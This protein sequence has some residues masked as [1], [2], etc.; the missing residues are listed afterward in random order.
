MSKSLLELFEKYEDTT[1]PKRPYIDIATCVVWEMLG[2][3]DDKLSQ[4]IVLYEELFNRYVHVLTTT[5][6][7]ANLNLAEP[8]SL[9][10]PWPIGQSW[11]VGGTH[12]APVW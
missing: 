8:F 2:K 3:V 5:F 9:D 11:F 7:A 6:N 1:L 10:W 4:F 12:G